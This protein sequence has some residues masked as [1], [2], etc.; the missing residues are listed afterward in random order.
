MFH[1]LKIFLQIELCLFKIFTQKK[2]NVIFI[3]KGLTSKL[4]PLETSLNR[5]FKDWIK[6]SYEDALSLFNGV[7]WAK[8]KREVILN[9]IYINWFDNEKIK[10]QIIKNTFLYC[11]FS[12][13]M[14][15][16]KM[17]YLRYLI[18]Q[19]NADLLKMFLLM[20]KKI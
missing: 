15:G 3:P 4:Q 12:N 13:N 11:G 2:I 5:P 6:R 1:I 20:I 8:I 17:N 19:T 16:Q 14:D 10:T 18:Y 9:W 7:K